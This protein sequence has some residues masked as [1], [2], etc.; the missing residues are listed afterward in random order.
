[1]TSKSLGRAL[2]IWQN[3]RQC[4]MKGWHLSPASAVQS[5]VRVS[6]L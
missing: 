1:M 5:V 3:C 4:G 2:P 6:Y